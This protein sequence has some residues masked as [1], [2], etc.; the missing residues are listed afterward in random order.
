MRQIEVIEGLR[1]RFPHRDSEFDDGL[2]IGLL[3]AAMARGDRRV[4]RRMPGHLLEQVRKVAEACGYRLSAS[5]LAGDLVDI[6]LLA[7]GQRPRLAVV[8]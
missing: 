7:P 4:A 2:E 6:V 8:R 1:L 5:E 3:L